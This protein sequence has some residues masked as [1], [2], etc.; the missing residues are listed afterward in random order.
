MAY[1]ECLG[2]SM[3]ARLQVAGLSDPGRARSL[4]EDSYYFKFLQASDQ[5]PIGLFIVADG[6]GGYLAGEV[7]SHWAI[8]TIKRENKYKFEEIQK[9]KI[10]NY[11]YEYFGAYPKILNMLV[12]IDSIRKILLENGET[13]KSIDKKDFLLSM[14]KYFYYLTECIDYGK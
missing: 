9:Y 2:G 11:F 1:F 7:A 8:E 5:E 6:L 3:V 13:E 14:N 10:K 12:L 4:N